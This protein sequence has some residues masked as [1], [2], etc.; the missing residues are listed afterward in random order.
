MEVADKIGAVAVTDAG[1]FEQ[2][3]VETVLIKSMRLI[4]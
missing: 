2:I 1:D 4:R 3:P